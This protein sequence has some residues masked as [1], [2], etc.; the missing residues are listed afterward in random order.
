MLSRWLLVSVVVIVLDQLS[1]AAITDHFVYGETLAVMPFFNEGQVVASTKLA[2]RPG[3]VE[4]RCSQHP[5]MHGYILVFDQPYYTVTSNDGSF[6]IDSLPP[7]TYNLMAWHEG[8]AKPVQKTIKVPAGG[9]TR[10]EV[11]L[12]LNGNR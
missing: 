1:K 12:A 4:I 10:T 8:A 7:G 9:T 6:K 2:S 11:T 5:W 3:V